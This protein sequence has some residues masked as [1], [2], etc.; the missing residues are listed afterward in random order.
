[1][2]VKVCGR[3]CSSLGVAGLWRNKNKQ[4]HQWTSS[5]Y[6]VNSIFFNHH[7]FQEPH[8]IT[9]E[10]Q[11]D[12]N[13]DFSQDVPTT[14]LYVVKKESLRSNLNDGQSKDSLFLFC[15]SPGDFYRQLACHAREGVL[16]RPEAT[17]WM[18]PD[19]GR[20]AQCSTGLQS[21]GLNSD[22]KTVSLYCVVKC[23]NGIVNNT[24]VSHWAL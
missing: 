24:D 20:R 22:T 3:W 10:W 23:K 17:V 21:A 14:L 4:Q 19:Q 5:Q 2:F 7:L 1:M 6:N 12:S 18:L 13:P 16:H 8:F 11:W 15:F 9:S